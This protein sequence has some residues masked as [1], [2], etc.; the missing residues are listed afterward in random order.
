MSN[1][2]KRRANR[3]HPNRATPYASRP[4][5]AGDFYFWAKEPKV[6]KNG[7]EISVPSSWPIIVKVEEGLASGRYCRELKMGGSAQCGLKE[8]SGI[9]KLRQKVA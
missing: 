2:A 7:C 3:V 5:Q 6:S 4:S 8:W 9:W 1:S